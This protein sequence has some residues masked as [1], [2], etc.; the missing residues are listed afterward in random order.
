MSCGRFLEE[1]W[2]DR[3]EGG[4]KEARKS[5]KGDWKEGGEEEGGVEQGRRK[6]KTKKI[7]R[8]E[9]RKRGGGERADG[10]PFRH[11]DKS[12][13]CLCRSPERL[14]PSPIPATLSLSR[15]LFLPFGVAVVVSTLSFVICS[16]FSVL[17]SLFSLVRSEFL[18]VAVPRPTEATL[19][20]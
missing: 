20:G 9:E 16:L 1:G 7:E 10:G 17:C 11:S 5:D 4:R 6:K 18:S 13:L 2:K 19:A 3:K 12:L 8:K 14:F 15:L